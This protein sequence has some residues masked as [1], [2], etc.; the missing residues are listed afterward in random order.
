VR[1]FFPSGTCN[2]GVCTY[3]EKATQCTYGCVEGECAGTLLLAA[4]PVGA[5]TITGDT[6]RCDFRE[7]NVTVA[8]G[9]TV[10]VTAVPAPGKVFDG[11]NRTHGFATECMLAG[12]IC[13]FV[14]PND[15]GLVLLA[16]FKDQ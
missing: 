2:Q 13:T 15:G 12:P 7:C 16:Q 6:I 1:G 14:M 8:P 9:T 4:I 11:W 5:G 10:T 3:D